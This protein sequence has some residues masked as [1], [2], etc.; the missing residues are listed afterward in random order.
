MKALEL[1]K[2]F[3]DFFEKRGH[4]H[5]PSSSLIP[6]DDPSVLLTTAGMQQFKKW[7]IGIE[8]PEFSKVVTIQKCVRI[9]DIEG[10]GDDTHHSFFEM[11]G[12]FSFNDYFK[13]EAIKWGIEFIQGELN[14][15]SDRISFTYFKGENQLPEDIESLEI[16]QSLNIPLEKIIGMGKDDNFWGPTGD[17]GPCGPTVEIYVDNVE[18]WNLVFNQYYYTEGQYKPLKFNGIDTGLGFERTLSLLNGKNNNFDTEL[19]SNIIL[20][21]EELSGNSKDKKSKRIIA[22]HLRAAVFLL[23]DGVLP[24]NLGKGYVLRRLIR[25]AVR[26]GKIIGIEN[27]FTLDVA[28]VVIEDYKEA[29]PELEKNKEFIQEELLKEENRFERTLEKGLSEFDKKYSDKKEITGEDAFYLFQTY[30]FPLEMT[31]ELADEKEIKV[32]E[33]GFRKAFEKHQE[34]SRKGA[35]KKFKGGLA[36][37]GENEIKYHTA[38]HL[39]H[40]ALRTILGDHVKQSGSNITEERLRF[41]FTHPEKLTPEQISSLAYLVNEEIRRGLPVV[42]E[43]MDTEQAKK[44][45]AIGLFES[46]YGDKVKVYIIGEIEKPYSMEICGGPHVNNTKE[47]GK[48]KIIKEEASSAG[49][50]RIKAILE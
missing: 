18:V 23:V 13:K 1:R 3:I 26:Y 12:N 6:K 39:L 24:N 43:E 46:K 34:I 30:G 42:C 2:K 38:T 40:Q 21:I 47:L 35:E 8:E 19:F 37:A 33:Q 31:K 45:G 25:R 20:K 15:S 29:Y 14:V 27:S 16:L 10:V 4:K 44:R 36:K 32:D 49:V 17:E 28:E 5:L 9:D 22:D 50:R 11:L 7:F 48:F 41:D